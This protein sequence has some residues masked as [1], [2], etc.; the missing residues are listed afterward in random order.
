MKIYPDVCCLCRLFDD[1][2]SHR[3]RMQ[4]EAVIAILNRCMTDWD[5]AGNE[6]IEYEIAGIA[7][8]ER[9]RTSTVTCIRASIDLLFTTVSRFYVTVTD[10]RNNFSGH[11]G[12]Q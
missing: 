5:L 3:I 8:E 1:Q 7:D 2:T 4:T 9:K 6:V 12:K 10:Y 11:A